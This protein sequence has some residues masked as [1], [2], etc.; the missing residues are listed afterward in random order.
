[1][2]HIDQKLQ[3]RNLSM[4]TQ[5]MSSE[6]QRPMH[7]QTALRGMLDRSLSRSSIIQPLVNYYLYRFS[8][9]FQI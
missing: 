1:M 9:L 6:E 7:T 4:Y 5:L 3:S 2:A 8:P